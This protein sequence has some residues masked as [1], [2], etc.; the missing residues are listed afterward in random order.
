M[1]YGNPSFFCFGV[2]I[3]GFSLFFR[4]IMNYFSRRSNTTYIFVHN[5]VNVFKYS[6]LFWGEGRKMIPF[7]KVLEEAREEVLDE[8]KPYVSVSSSV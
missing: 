3:L 5:P 8:E 1:K 7:L 4:C 2:C 6:S